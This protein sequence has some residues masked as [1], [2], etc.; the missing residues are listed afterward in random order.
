MINKTTT[1][2][3][4]IFGNPVILLKLSMTLELIHEG[5]LQIP[6]VLS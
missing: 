5:V 1:K 6:H 3:M 4:K 2:L